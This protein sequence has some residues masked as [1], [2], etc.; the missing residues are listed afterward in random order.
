MAM[1]QGK[2]IIGQDAVI[3]LDRVVPPAKPE[4]GGAQKTISFRWKNHDIFT[5][6]DIYLVRNDKS[7]KLVTYTLSDGAVS[8]ATPNEISYGTI[9]G[10]ESNTIYK[11]VVNQAGR[12]VAVP[13]NEYTVT[14]T[15]TWKEH[16][17]DFHKKYPVFKFRIEMVGNPSIFSE[18][19]EFKVVY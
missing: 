3:F 19:N 7:K 4:N 13:G 6:V 2:P 12:F 14:Y 9:K 11:T 18:T 5:E 15:F 10:K 17:R 16:Y 1:Q 8:P